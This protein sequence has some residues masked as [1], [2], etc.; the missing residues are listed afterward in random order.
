MA[1]E[2]GFYWVRIGGGWE[3]AQTFMGMW[4]LAGMACTFSDKQFLEIG[5]RIPE[6]GS[7][8]RT[9]RALEV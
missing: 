5:E 6:P 8:Q 2:D 9:G 3:V 4:T 7:E 1:R